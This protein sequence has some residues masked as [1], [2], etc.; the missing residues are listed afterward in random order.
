MID[1]SNADRFKTAAEF[2]HTYRGPQQV[3][4]TQPASTSGTSD[5]LGSRPETSKQQAGQR[6]VIE[7]YQRENRRMQQELEELWNQV[8]SAN[9]VAEALQQEVQSLYIEKEAYQREN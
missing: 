9:R 8:S 6:E 4:E 1:E 5:A 2:Y 3:H 7:V